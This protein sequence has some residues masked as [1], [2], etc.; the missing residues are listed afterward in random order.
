MR[1]AIVI[2]ASVIGM[3]AGAKNCRNCRCARK[4]SPTRICAQRHSRARDQR[5]R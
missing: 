4:L 2:I 5:N 3:P 1:Y